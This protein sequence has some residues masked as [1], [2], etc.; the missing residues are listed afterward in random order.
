M[1]TPLDSEYSSASA[2]MIFVLEYQRASLFYFASN[3]PLLAFA[4]YANNH[5]DAISA[6]ADVS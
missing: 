5:I 4:Y 3:H 2:Q 6:F 1:L